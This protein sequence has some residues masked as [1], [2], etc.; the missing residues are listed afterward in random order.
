MSRTA[1][2]GWRY[3]REE[4]A[5][6]RMLIRVSAEVSE[7][8]LGPF[9]GLTPTLEPAQTTLTGMVRDQAELQGVLNYLTQ[10]GV[11]IVEVVTIPEEREHDDGGSAPP[12]AA[13]GH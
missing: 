4:V 9:P 3:V 10:L 6:P 5:M 11:A 8:M 13:R 1:I 12:R 7:E 2:D